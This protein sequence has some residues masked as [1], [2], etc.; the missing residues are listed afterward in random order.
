MQPGPHL[1]SQPPA[2]TAFSASPSR[3][4]LSVAPGLPFS[5]SSGPTNPH[6]SAPH[7]SN[8]PQSIMPGPSSLV[9][10]LVPEDELDEGDFASGPTPLLPLPIVP[11]PP[12]ASEASERGPCGPR[13]PTPPLERLKDGVSRLS[14]VI[15]AHLLRILK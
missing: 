4:F 11:P 7:N 15:Y 1:L 13:P 9:P 8:P 12:R 5:D 6:Y 3:A 2:D 10:L 14:L